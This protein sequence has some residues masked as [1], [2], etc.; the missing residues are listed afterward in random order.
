MCVLSF[1][2]KRLSASPLVLVAASCF[3]CEPV[4]P[5]GM[6]EEGGVGGTGGDAPHIRAS[7]LVSP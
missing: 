6:S 7:G 2:A 3:K 5:V 1:P 4:F